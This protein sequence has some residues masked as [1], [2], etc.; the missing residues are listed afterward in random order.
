MIVLEVFDELSNDDGKVH[1]VLTLASNKSMSD[2][3]RS[4]LW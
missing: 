2:K 1:G 3:G 4:E